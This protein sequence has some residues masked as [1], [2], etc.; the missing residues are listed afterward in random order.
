M[1]YPFSCL[2]I[3]LFS[4][5]LATA[6]VLIGPI[7]SLSPPVSSTSSLLDGLNDRQ[8]AAVTS[9]NVSLAVVAGAGSG[10]TSVLTKRIAWLLAQHPDWRSSRI[11]AVTF[12]NK[13]AREMTDRL[14]K[15]DVPVSGMWVGTFHGLANRFLRLNHEAA[16][17]KKSFII[18]DASDSE[19][20]VNTIFKERR[21]PMWD[22]AA[23][24]VSSWIS[25]WKDAGLRPNFVPQ[26]TPEAV[27]GAEIYRIYQERC[28]EN[29]WVDFGELL[30][31]T[32][33]T[34][35]RHDVILE[36]M[37]SRFSHVLVDEFQDTNLIQYRW[38]ALLTD[39]GSIIP[40]TVVGDMDQSIYSWR[41]AQM[42]HL[43]DFVDQFAGASIIKLEQN[44]RSTG[45]ILATA[46]ALIA[47]NTQ[48]IDKDLWTDAGAGEPV[49]LV[50]TDDDRNEA[51]H[52]VALAK[53]QYTLSHRWRD[54]VALY[55]FN[56]QSRLLEEA[57]N[58]ARIP[59]QIHGGLRFFDRQ[60]IKDA[61]A[62]LGVLA[63]HSNDMAL[64]RALGAPTK[65]FGAANI[66]TLRLWSAKNRPSGAP[67]LPSL[68]ALCDA[69]TGAAPLS[70]PWNA[71][72]TSLLSASARKA[73]NAIRGRWDEAS[74][75]DFR[76]QVLWCVN[77]S[78][79]LA[80]YQERDRKDHTD[81]AE[82][83]KELVSS[84][85]RFV[86]ESKRQG[87][88]ST[89]EEFL[90]TAVLDSDKQADAPDIDAVQMMTIHA[91]KG[92]EFPSV[93]LVGW[94]E[95]LFPAPRAIASED[96]SLLEEERRLAYVAITRAERT[97]HIVGSA[98]RMRFG[99]ISEFSPSRFLAELPTDH[100]VWWAPPRRSGSPAASVA[101]A[102]GLGPAVPARTAR[103]PIP[104]FW[105]PGQ[106]VRHPT[107]GLGRVVRADGP[108][109]D[110][111]VLVHF[112]NGKNTMLLPAI[113]KLSKAS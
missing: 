27:T 78:G 54:T 40:A 15:L 95:E 64:E 24:E 89:A 85:T 111:R 45:H 28:E 97:A 58:A 112:D 12:T 75:L 110:D 79:L 25:K 51:R 16:N 41:G 82:N 46:N 21:L 73:W 76:D 17:L 43:Q 30:L 77:E 72:P 9:G 39:R 91:A 36:N 94:D 65:G 71:P 11:M 20:L 26:P 3:L 8:L 48:R 104:T 2:N 113:A 74:A 61:L 98:R 90:A 5:T 101:H 14:E 69:V 57:L 83:L 105:L 33:E 19:K 4:G 70:G 38:L 66:D 109:Q 86:E 1:L 52:V 88:P 23:R 68:W 108:H 50:E 34:M 13:A 67:R 44:Y 31:R 92:L 10:K 99:R 84:A 53:H 56:Y 103:T 59:Y 102:P 80:H 6:L 32:V 60:E 49:V 18:L 87:L 100:V 22:G 62:H 106:R 96:P 93:C 107:F 55:R 81:R 35:E 47:H 7:M 63:D 42:T 29:S 37:R